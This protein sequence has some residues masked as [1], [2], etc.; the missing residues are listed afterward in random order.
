M[1]LGGEVGAIRLQHEPLDALLSKRLAHGVGALVGGDPSER[2][3]ATALNDLCHL[4]SPV[5]EAVEDDALP[6]DARLIDQLDALFKAI[7]AVDN[8]WALKLGSQHELL[9]EGRLLHEYDLSR[10]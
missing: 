1:W 6:V 7:A 10:L 2:S 9:P 8:D 3:S 5:G 4:F